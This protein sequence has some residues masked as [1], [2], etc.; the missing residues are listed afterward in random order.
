[1]LGCAKEEDTSSAETETLTEPNIPDTPDIVQETPEQSISPLMDKFLRKS[2]GSMNVSAG[3]QI[4]AFFDLVEYGLH[5]HPRD[6]MKIYFE[7][8]VEAEV[9]RDHVWKNKTFRKILDEYCQENNLVWTIIG[10]D[11]I[12]ISK[13]TM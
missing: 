6:P 12:R 13:K 5:N 11:T 9:E 7:I 10:P 2:Y 8:E 1:M 3:N 4:R